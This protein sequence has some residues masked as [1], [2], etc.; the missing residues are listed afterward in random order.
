M[1][2]RTE[3]ATATAFHAEAQRTAFGFKGH[4]KPKDQTQKRFNSAHPA[5]SAHPANAQ[6][7]TRGVMNRMAGMTARISNGKVNGHGNCT[8]RLQAGLWALQP[9]ATETAW[10][11]FCAAMVPAA[12]VV[13]SSGAAGLFSF[14][15]CGPA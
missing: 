12:P 14:D 15:A 2:R 8:L 3:A 13:A 10:P 11:E 6:H 9:S 7:A 4:G 1:P 5:Y